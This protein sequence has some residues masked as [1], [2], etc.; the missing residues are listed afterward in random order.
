M[1]EMQDEPDLQKQEVIKQIL[2]EDDHHGH[3]SHHG[4]ADHK[5]L[6]DNSHHDNHDSRY[7]I[8]QHVTPQFTTQTIRRRNWMKVLNT[9]SP[10][11]ARN[12]SI[13]IKDFLHGLCKGNVNFKNQINKGE[14]PFEVIRPDVVDYLDKFSGEKDQS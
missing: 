11:T 3:D 1:Q 12:Y 10:V 2:D 8:H 6:F 4:Y 13:H 9:K 14:V 7:Q 5:A